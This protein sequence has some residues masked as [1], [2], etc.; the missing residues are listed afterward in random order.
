MR[1]KE[2][3]ITDISEIEAI[4]NKAD[5]CRLAMADGAP[6]YVSALS[7]TAAK[8]IP[9]S[10]IFCCRFCLWILRSRAASETLP[11][12]SISAATMISFSNWNL[13][14]RSGLDEVERDSRPDLLSLRR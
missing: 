13:A 7:E 6:K 3:E 1:K 14:S 12:D 2:Y 10:L 11:P 4:L 8:S 5:I 9:S